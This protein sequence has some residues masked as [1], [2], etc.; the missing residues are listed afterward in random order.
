MWVD[1]GQ[2]LLG[3]DVEAVLLIKKGVLGGVKFQEVLLIG[4]P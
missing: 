1:G 4:C 3:R 2:D